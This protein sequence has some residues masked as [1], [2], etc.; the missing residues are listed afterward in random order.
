MR[1][2][3]LG[4]A[5]DGKPLAGARPAHEAGKGFVQRHVISHPEPAVGRLMDQQFGQLGLRPIDEGAQQR[6]VEPAERGVGGDPADVGL[7]TLASQAL[8]GADGGI[9]REVAPIGGAAGERMAPLTGRQ[10]ERRRGNH[11]PQH[12]TAL[13]VCETPVAGAG[14]QTHFRLG[15]PQN[16]PGPPQLGLERC[17]GR[18]VRQQRIDRLRCP[19]YPPMPTHRL[20]VVVEVCAPA[21]RNRRHQQKRRHRPSDRAACVQGSSIN[22]CSP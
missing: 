2:E 15:K 9:A 7:Q 22:P 14:V 8:R 19:Q 5:L 4:P 21:Q 1:R 18:W 16:L 20:G 13:K 3:L 10:R 11:I 17:R 6:I 12:V